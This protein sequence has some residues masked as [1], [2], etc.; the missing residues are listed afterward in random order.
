[1]ETQLWRVRWSQEL[2]EG[3]GSSAQKAA[4]HCGHHRTEK[5]VIQISVA[6]E[7]AWDKIV[8][9][10]KS[11]KYENAAD[12]LHRDSNP[13]DHSRA[14]Q[15]IGN[16]YF[17]TRFLVDLAHYFGQISCNLVN[18]P[19][20]T[21]LREPSQSLFSQLCNFLWDLLTCAHRLLTALSANL[22]FL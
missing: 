9:Q 7:D 1:M 8:E 19:Y 15:S 18:W 10:E 6:S 4:C 21:P 22:I 5:N 16:C 17:L 12:H 2:V 14:S 20:I 3:R 13:I 11:G